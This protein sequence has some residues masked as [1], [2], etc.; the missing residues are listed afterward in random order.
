VVTVAG[1]DGVVSF[2]GLT[3]S[4][5]GLYQINVTLPGSLPSGSQQLQVV[6]NGIPSNS[7]RVAIR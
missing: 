6:S 5:V 3:P 2:S 1:R 4:Y 7:V